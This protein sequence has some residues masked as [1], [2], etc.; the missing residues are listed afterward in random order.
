MFIVQL[1][2]HMSVCIA[3]FF[4]LDI[5]GAVE[6]LDTWELL[7]SSFFTDIYVLSVLLELSKSLYRGRGSIA[8]EQISSL[9]CL[10]RRWMSNNTENCHEEGYIMKRNRW[11]YRNLI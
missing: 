3:K 9:I 7:L 8:A 10:S 5:D 6:Q 2:F 1:S 11:E 4:S